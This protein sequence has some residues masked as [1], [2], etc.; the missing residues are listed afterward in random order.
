M[1]R[2]TCDGHPEVE[3]GIFWFPLTQD[4]Q[5]TSVNTMDMN[6]TLTESLHEQDGVFIDIYYSVH[7]PYS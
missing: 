2:S 5:A 6:H 1:A 7:I 3:E 4:S